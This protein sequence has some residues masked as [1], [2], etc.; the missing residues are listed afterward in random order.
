MTPTHLGRIPAVALGGRQ[1]G[2]GGIAAFL[3]R[4]GAVLLAVAGAA[5]QELKVDINNNNRPVLEGLDPAYLPWSTNALWFAGGDA[6]S[7]TL[8]GIT[9]T[10]T[11]VGP[12]GTGLAPGY[13]K[14]GVQNAAYHAKLVSDGIKVSNGDA[15]GRIEMRLAGLSAGSHTLLTYH[16]VWDNLSTGSVAPLQ[17]SV[18]GV[19]VVTNLAMTVR[20]T[21]NADSATAYLELEAVAGREVVVLFEAETNTAASVKNVYINGFEIDTAH[22]SRR[23]ANP[24]PAHG[25][26]HVAADDKAVLLNWTPAASAV[27]HDVYFGTESNEVAL[28]S[29]VSPVFKG[30]QT[31]SNHLASG[32]SSLRTYFWR[33]D[34]VDASGSVAR[35]EL[36][37]FRLRHLAFPGAEGYGR[38]ARGGRGGVVVEV[39]HLN[40]SG[41]GSLRDA[42]TGNYGPR[43]V[44]FTV[45]GL[46]TLES[47]LIINQNHPCLTLAGQT[48]PGKGICVRK[49]QLGI[50]GGR[51]VI[52]RHI[53]SRP[54]DL[55]G[56]TLN[57]S[58]MAGSDH[59]IMDHCSISWGIDE[60][61]STRNCRNVTLQ[62]TL[63]SEA[64]NLAGHENYPPGTAHGYAASIG[65]DIGSFHHN[66]LAHCE[67]RNWSLA[68]GLD[69]AGYFAGRLDIFNN[70]VYNWGHRTTD[71]GA[72]EVNFVNNYYK[73]GPASSFFYALNAQYGNFPGT[74]QYYF[75][76]NVMPGHFDESN[77][78]AGRMASPENGGSVPTNYSPW[79]SIPFFP[80]DAEIQSAREAYQS[81]LSDVGC[82]QP[83]LDDHD[84]RVI[85]E[86]LSGTVTFYGSISHY[87]GLPDSQEDVGG[88]EDYP[89]VSRPTGWD[90]DHDGLP[91]WWERIKGLNPNSAPGDYS[92]SNADL[93][94]DEYTELE[95][96]LHW[97]ATP[98]YDCP[99]GGA[100]DVDLAALSRGF[101][102]HPVYSITTV[103]NG[104]AQILSDGR[105]VRFTPGES[106]ESLAGFGF[107]VADAANRVMT[108]AVGIHVLPGVAPSAP[109]LG[110]GRQEHSLVLDLVGPAGRSLVVERATALGGEWV[111]WTN[112]VASGTNQFIFLQGLAAESSLFFRAFTQ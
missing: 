51:D 33:V 66:L 15:G 80:S 91:D 45:G 55:S 5:G 39:T 68:G 58:G 105:T 50:S 112:L 13:W 40:D 77:Q 42:L 99:A 35:G 54:G 19:R 43:T 106:R 49:S 69:A 38:F 37:Q 44:V 88:W 87:P 63:I 98:H 34:E 89:Q 75:N 1:T 92:D 111:R 59:C 29:R 79:V 3:A 31:A 28:A 85:G 61:M 17:V 95:R 8:G 10:F 16:T 64:L 97:M 76:G 86:T 57:G 21:N 26:E 14:E 73:P 48:A 65:G 11:R 70:V 7:N 102:D 6:T 78:A 81:V 101:Q 22:S 100:L 104:T 4:A 110:I 109:R 83:A 103:S 93:E 46:I 41:P 74:Q 12:H 9:V 20:V 84:A 56:R 27:S 62:R 30:N 18:D 47:D 71:G 82:T 67:G 108:R 2:F 36:W 52:V 53:R 72:H 107:S 60:E 90:T 32:L 24:S 96:Y 25:D 23:A 94:G